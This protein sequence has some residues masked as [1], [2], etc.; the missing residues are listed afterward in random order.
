MKTK[1]FF[2]LGLVCLIFISYDLFLRIH[3]FN[4]IVNVIHTQNRAENLE[5]W[6]MLVERYREI[7][8][9]HLSNSLIIIWVGLLMGILSSLSFFLTLSYIKKTP[10]FIKKVFVEKTILIMMFIS[11]I[12]ITTLNL[13]MSMSYYSIP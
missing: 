10:H 9:Y 4:T 13:F 7:N 6:K 11:T 1:L 12:V 2:C 5:R 3:L 8:L